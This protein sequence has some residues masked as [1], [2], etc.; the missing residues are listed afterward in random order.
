MTDTIITRFAPSPTGFLHIGGARTAL[1]NWLFARRHGGKFCLRI[2][3]TDRQRS[4]DEA[5]DKIISGLR[6]LGLDWD[7]EI[8][9]QFS[10]AKRHAEIAWQLLEAGQAYRC[11]CSPEELAARREAAKASNAPQR[12]NRRCRDN[13]NIIQNKPFAIRLKAPTTGNIIVNDLVQGT[14]QFSCS[15]LDDMILLRSEGTP[16]YM[17]SVVVDDRDMNITHVIRGDDHLTNTAR[18]IILY[19]ALD[20]HIPQFA[21]LPMIHGIDGTKL[22]KR[23][24]AVGIETY[25]ELGYLPETLRNYLLRLGWS[26]GDDEI[27]STDQAIAWFDFA[28]AGRSPARLD[29][30]KLDNLNGHYIRLAN[31]TDLVSEI[32]DQMEHI[33]GRE[34]LPLDYTRLHAAMPCIKSR[35]KNLVQLAELARFLVLARPLKIADKIKP[36]ADGLQQLKALGDYLSDMMEWS[37]VSIEGRVRLFAAEKN[38]AFGDIAK[39]LRIALTASLISPPIFEV[40]AILGKTETCGRIC[41]IIGAEFNNC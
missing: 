20:W 13:H 4:T 19:Q 9:M 30:A 32:K 40:A 25:R 16:T 28:H 36:N 12:Y 11:Y 7:G 6:W 39:L 33:A 3:D 29:F 22:S 5:I 35:A 10:R 23:H 37:N 21:H 27:I 2:E 17:L 14:V 24:G 18:Q 41:D 8:I 26:H 34:L 31:D 38:I 15:E 1:F